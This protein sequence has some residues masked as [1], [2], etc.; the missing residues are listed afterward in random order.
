MV[1]FQEERVKDVMPEL[2]TEEVV[3]ICSDEKTGGIKNERRAWR[4]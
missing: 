4:A 2:A 3:G 1:K